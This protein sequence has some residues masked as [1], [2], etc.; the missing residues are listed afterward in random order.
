MAI[1][2]RVRIEDEVV[3]RALADPELVAGPIRR[4]LNK[5]ALVVEAGAKERSPV[6]TG[7]LRSSITHQV[8]SAEATVGTRLIYA[9]WVEFGTKPHWPPMR[10]MQ[11]WA[12]RHGF[13]AGKVG[14]F[15]VARAIAKH[16]TKPQPYLRP[17]LQA[18]LPDVRRFLEDAARE[19][20]GRWSG[21]G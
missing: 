2:I 17:A 10:A 1:E 20:E 19:I 13:P 18:S 16:G 11:P 9:P 5:S 14:A 4:F 12:K 3:R 15:L 7:R 21:H 6:D 8:A